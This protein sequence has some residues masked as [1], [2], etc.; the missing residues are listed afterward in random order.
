M[1]R[2]AVIGLDTDK[3]KL[4]SSLMDF[5]AVQLTDQTG[6]FEESLWKDWT[7][8]DEN[9]RSQPLLSSRSMMPDENLYS[10]PEEWFQKP[11]LYLLEII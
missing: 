6:K 1:Q 8:Q 2:I 7:V 3:E 10:K 4:V 5:G 11:I 9:Q